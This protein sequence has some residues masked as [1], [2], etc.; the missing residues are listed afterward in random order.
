[1]AVAAVSCA[2]DDSAQRSAGQEQSEQEQSAQTDPEAAQ[3]PGPCRE[4]IEDADGEPTAV[5]RLSYDEQGRRVE[6]RVVQPSDG[7]VDKIERKVYEDGKLV[8]EVVEDPQSGREEPR[9]LAH[10]YDDRGMRVR[11]EE[12]FRG[13]PEPDTITRYSYD[14]QARL[15]R[16]VEDFDLDGQPDS[17]FVQA[18]DEQ[19]QLVRRTKYQGPPDEVE[20]PEWDQSF[21]YD[22]QGRRIARLEDSDAD[23]DVDVRVEFTHD[24]HGN[25][26]ERTTDF[27][28]QPGV[29]ERVVFERTYDD[30]GRQ[31]RVETYSVSPSGSHQLMSA[32]DFDYRC[33]D[34]E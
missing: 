25:V 5:H 8:R 15:V 6:E 33:E 12:D 26:V 29:D 21:E 14:E 27:T 24:E 17:V 28:I 10:V 7:T 13:D 4:T 11:T 20:A 23:G 30:Q 31:V 22:D 18:F 34:R 9:T 16:E 32:T 1:M 2:N 3:P 19:D